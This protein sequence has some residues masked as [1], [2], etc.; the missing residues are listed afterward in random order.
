MPVNKKR[1]LSCMELIRLFQ[2]GSKSPLINMMNVWETYKE[3]CCYYCFHLNCLKYFKIT[4]LSSNGK[5]PLVSFWPNLSSKTVFS[6]ED[7][8]RWFW[9]A[10]ERFNICIEI[11]EKWSYGNPSQRKS[12][13]WYATIR[14][15]KNVLSI[16]FGEKQTE[17][18]T[19]QMHH[20]FCSKPNKIERVLTSL[21]IK[22]AEIRFATADSFCTVPQLQ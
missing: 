18:P 17:L 2:W 15:W 13:F 4:R 7:G 1:A 20:F 11:G 5:F 8:R 10:C 3:S 21:W 6:R 19:H 12:C 14:L 16:C 9:C 22:I